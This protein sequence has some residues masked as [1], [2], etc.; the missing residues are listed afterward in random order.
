[1]ADGRV[2]ASSHRCDGILRPDGGQ[3]LGAHRGQ[4]HAAD[5]YGACMLPRGRKDQAHQDHV[6]GEAG[7]A[8]HVRQRHG[9]LTVGP[10]GAELLSQ[11][12]AGH[13]G[14]LRR[15]GAAQ[16]GPP[17][18]PH[19]Q[20]HPGLRQGHQ[21]S[22]G[23]AWRGVHRPSHS[24]GHAARTL[25]ESVGRLVRPE[26]DHVR[27]EASRRRVRVQAGQGPIWEGRGRLA[28]HQAAEAR[29]LPRASRHA[30]VQDS[31]RAV[32]RALGAGD[33]RRGAA[34]RSREQQEG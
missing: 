11:P 2:G 26:G 20:R 31:P 4:Y 21:A 24:H 16:H 22:G 32:G 33:V 29:G 13:G 7:D 25:W 23:E 6:L 12:E 8:V 10:A 1:M 5:N 27:Q 34:S 9:H 28:K 17:L 14:G 19:P 30:L 18:P 3:A 15:R